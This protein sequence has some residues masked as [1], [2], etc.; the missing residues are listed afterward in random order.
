LTKSEADSNLY[1]FVKE[2]KTIMILL[3]VDD[4]L[5]TGDNEEELNRIQSALQEDFE[6]TDLGIAQ[7]YLGAEFEYHSLGIYVH[8][9]SYI[10]RVLEKVQ[11][12]K[13]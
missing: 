8:Q 9:R 2:G 10:K 6:M 7:N 5:L 11:L 12:S 4:L 1:Y 13:L 3:Y